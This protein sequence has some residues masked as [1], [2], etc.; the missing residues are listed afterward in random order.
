[1]VHV[2]Q[3]S[4]IP[5]LQ[6]PSATLTTNTNQSTVARTWCDARCNPIPLKRNAAR[7]SLR[8][9]SRAK[10]EPS[11]KPEQLKP[12]KRPTRREQKYSEHWQQSEHH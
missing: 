4:Y 11:L 12:S 6:N 5:L 2:E 8:S 3:V 1:M 7:L 9:F 10:K